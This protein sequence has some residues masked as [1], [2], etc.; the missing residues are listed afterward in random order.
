[1]ELITEL[2]DKEIVVV[3]EKEHDGGLSITE[4]VDRMTGEPVTLWPFEEETI[5]EQC[6][7]DYNQN[8]D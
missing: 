7:N 5:L 2:E 3:Y 4:A 8:H 1:M 6:W